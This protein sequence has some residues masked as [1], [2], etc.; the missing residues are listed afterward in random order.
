MAQIR[1]MHYEPLPTI[2]LLT[3]PIH[4]HLPKKPSHLYVLTLTTSSDDSPRP[5]KEAAYQLAIK[6]ETTRHPSQEGSLTLQSPNGI[7]TTRENPMQ[8]TH[9]KDQ[10][11]RAI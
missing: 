9:D 6:D 2:P 5:K 1:Q 3:S 4:N 8:V 11:S 10:A 7:N